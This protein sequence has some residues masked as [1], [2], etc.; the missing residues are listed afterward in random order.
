MVSSQLSL[1][2]SGV[3]VRPCTNKSAFLD[4]SDQLPC[5]LLLS[6][7]QSYLEA[8]S[9]QSDSVVNEL[10]LHTGHQNFLGA[11]ARPVVKL[12]RAGGSMAS[13]TCC[14]DGCF[15]LHCTALHRTALHC[16]TLGVYCFPQGQQSCISAVAGA[17]LTDRLGMH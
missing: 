3:T 10:I 16:T 6:A 9:Q 8:N 12:T 2:P 7:H 14:C 17:A 11:A 15:P 5:C 4:F 13:S 1:L